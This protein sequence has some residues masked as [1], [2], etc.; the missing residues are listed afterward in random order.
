MN[1]SILANLFKKGA[2]LGFDEGQ[3]D[4]LFRKASKPGYS[5]DKSY[6]V[7]DSIP[8]F[9]DGHTAPRFDDTPVAQ[10]VDDGGSFSL[11]E[12]LQ[13]YHTQPSDYFSPVGARYYGY[14]DPIGMESYAAIRNLMDRGGSTIRAYRAV[15]NDTPVDNL[16]DEDWITLSP[17]YAQQHGASRFGDGQY[18]IIQQDVPTNNVWWDGN[19][20]NEWGF[21]TGSGIAERQREA[22]QNLLFELWDLANK[23]RGQ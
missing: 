3:I 17:Q 19:D 8:S 1:G 11:D 16:I 18:R 9:R 22:Q 23:D 15:P 2:K 6:F 5:H 12:V 14:D 20:I 7:G 4:D 21:D 13:G 10:R